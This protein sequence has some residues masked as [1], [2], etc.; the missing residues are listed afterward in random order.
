LAS[1]MSK[2]GDVFVTNDERLDQINEIK[3]LILRD[4]PE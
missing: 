3:V 2:N 1:V 4:L